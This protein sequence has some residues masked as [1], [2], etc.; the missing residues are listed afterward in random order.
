MENRRVRNYNIYS[1]RTSELDKLLPTLK[2]DQVEYAVDH[3]KVHFKNPISPSLVKER[4]GCQMVEAIPKR[5]PK[6][7]GKPAKKNGTLPKRKPKKEHKPGRV[8]K[9]N[10]FYDEIFKKYEKKIVNRILRLKRCW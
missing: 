1:A 7:E 6:M 10:S 3:Y 4:S 5:K 8:A 9:K 2:A